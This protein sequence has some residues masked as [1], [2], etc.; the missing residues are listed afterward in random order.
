MLRRGS[1]PPPTLLS[2]G[3]KVA[4]NWGQLAT[5]E[6]MWK[7]KVRYKLMTHWYLEVWQAD[8]MAT[9]RPKL[10]TVPPLT[11]IPFPVGL[12]IPMNLSNI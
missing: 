6:T 10:C 7:V 4:K 2:L 9:L 3:F 1:D 12:K 5:L 11:Q 8:P